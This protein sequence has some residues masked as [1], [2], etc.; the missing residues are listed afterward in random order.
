MALKK[1][2]GP[3]TSLSFLGI[4]LDSSKFTTRQADK[5]TGK[6]DQFVSHEKGYKRQIL[7]LIGSLH[8][9]TKVVYH[10]GTLILSVECIPQL[11]R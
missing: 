9:A 11:P 4:I 2:E 8:H 1:V 3:A 10:C 5:H 7:S 6:T